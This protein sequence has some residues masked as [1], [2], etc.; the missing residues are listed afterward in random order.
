MKLITAEDI[1]NGVKVYIAGERDQWQ[2]K[3][4]YYKNPEYYCEIMCINLKDYDPEEYEP[5]CPCYTIYCFERRY[6][7][8]YHFDKKF[9]NCG[10]FTLDS[11]LHFFNSKEI[12]DI[13]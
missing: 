3:H 11:V 13:V 2:R 12:E 6:N 7:V 8:V 9:L 5:N 1:Y 4:C 10:S